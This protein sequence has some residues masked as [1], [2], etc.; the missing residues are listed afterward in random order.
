VRRAKKAIVGV[1]QDERV[2]YIADKLRD[3]IIFL[4]YHAVMSSPGARDEPVVKCKPFSMVPFA[5]DPKFVGREELLVVLEEKL[6]HNAKATHNRV[7]LV[8]LG[9]VG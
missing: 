8:G 1:H 5:R 6:Q 7:A 3:H 9:G 4:T 2:R